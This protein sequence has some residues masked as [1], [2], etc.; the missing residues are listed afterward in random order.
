MTGQIVV[1]STQVFDAVISGAV[2]LGLSAVAFFFRQWAM[3]FGRRI[4]H[5]DEKLDEGIERIARLE[6]PIPPGRWR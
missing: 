5:I 4:D 1:D 3:G 6:G 2:L